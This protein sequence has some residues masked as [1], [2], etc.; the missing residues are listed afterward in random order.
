MIAK[1]EQRE[2]KHGP[3][4]CNEGSSLAIRVQC[5]ISRNILSWYRPQIVDTDEKDIHSANEI[6]DKNL[7]SWAEKSEGK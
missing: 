6:L 5:T 7:S 3:G 4:L 1:G 2:K